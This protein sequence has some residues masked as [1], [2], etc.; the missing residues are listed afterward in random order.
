L[1]SSCDSRQ[2]HVAYTLNS[3]NTRYTMIP[4]TFLFSQIP[5]FR[6]V[7][8]KI[9]MAVRRRDQGSHVPKPYC[10]VSQKGVWYLFPH[11]AASKLLVTTQLQVLSPCLDNLFDLLANG[12]VWE[13]LVRPRPSLAFLATV[14]HYS[15]LSATSEVL[16]GCLKRF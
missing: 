10:H 1:S 3:E 12:F 7:E 14:G 4:L 11:H 6:A 15:T 2:L 13:T 5:E 8:R 16:P 9:G